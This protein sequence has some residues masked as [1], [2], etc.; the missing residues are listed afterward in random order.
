MANLQQLREKVRTQTETTVTEL[1]D[2]TIDGYLQEAYNRTL[3]AET[4]WP[5]FEHTW[6]VN[7]EVGSASLIEPPDCGEIV[8]LID[9]VTPC[10]LEMLNYEQAEDMFMGSLTTVG[11]ARAFSRWNGELVLWP[12]VTYEE[13][14]I[15]QLRGF[16]TPADWISQGAAA[17]PDCDPRLH[18]CLANYAIALAYAQQEDLELESNYMDRWA[19]DAEL[20]RQAIMGAD[21]HRPLVMGRRFVTPI[22]PSYNMPPFVVDVG[23]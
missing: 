3:A 9:T 21:F 23:T 8:S 19:R 12:A 2:A 17:E 22:G 14:R 16:R 5:F 20:A 10:R 11:T 4:F 6:Q 15:F 13:I 7:Q 1:P 18:L